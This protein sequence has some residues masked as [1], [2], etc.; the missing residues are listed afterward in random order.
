MSG[1]SR[2]RNPVLVHAAEP[3]RHSHDGSVLRLQFL[4]MALAGAPDVPE[5]Q[6]LLVEDG[7]ELRHA[8]WLTTNTGGHEFY[9]HVA[10]F[11]ELL[12]VTCLYDDPADHA[13]ARHVLNSVRYGV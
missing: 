9:G 12:L 6:Q 2:R 8:L 11:G 5:D 7:V 1:Q 3:L 13:W 4:E 10:R